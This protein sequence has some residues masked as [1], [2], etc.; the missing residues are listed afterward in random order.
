MD[1]TFEK[2]YIGIRRK[3]G[4]IYTDRELKMLPD[5]AFSHP[6]YREW[7]IR[8]RSCLKLVTYLK[9]IPGPLKILEIGC[10]NGW[11]AARLSELPDSEVIGLDINQSELQQ[12][13]RVFIDHTNLRFIYADIS[14]GRLQ[15]MKFNV[16][17]FAASIQYFPRLGNILGT[18]MQHLETNGEIHITDTHFYKPDKVAAARQRTAA[19]YA[20]LGFPEMAGRYFHHNIAELRPFHHEVLY[21][22]FSFKNR[23]FGDNHPFYWIRIKN[24]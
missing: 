16:I 3:E 2:D 17:L 10:G 20:A 5:V 11:L 9:N 6:H 7:M 23:W 22:P 4:R 14:S 12:A 13:A 8:K 15:H 1:S 21:D 24:K 19:Y 18:A